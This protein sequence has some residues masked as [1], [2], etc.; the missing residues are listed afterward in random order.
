MKRFL[1]RLS[2]ANVVSTICLFLVLGG[3]AAIA[4]GL[5]KNTVGTRQLK[6]NAVTSA[7][8]KDGSL[9]A[10]DLK[11]G[12]IPDAYTKSQSD[13]RYLQGTITITAE[14][15][16]VAKESF[17]GK[18][19]KCPSG[20]EAIGGGVSPQNV[21]TAAVSESAA[22]VGGKDVGTLPDGQHAAA[23]GWIGEV[24]SLTAALP[25]G[26]KVVVICSPIG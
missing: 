21:L 22:T 5:G 23:D 8:V 1:P 16:A 7:K 11:A 12:A 14:I 24:R 17:A 15:G 2:Y 3:G 19:V 6:R 26:S 18:I 10:G 13:N 25:A 4:A 20:Y 9:R